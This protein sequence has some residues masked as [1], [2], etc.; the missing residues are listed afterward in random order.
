MGAH[1]SARHPAISPAHISPPSSLQPA[2]ST[3]LLPPPCSQNAPPQATQRAIERLYGQILAKIGQDIRRTSLRP[4]GIAYCRIL[5]I[6]RQWII[7]FVVCCVHTHGSSTCAHGAQ[8][9][10]GAIVWRLPRSAPP[11]IRSSACLPSLALP[12][13]RPLAWNGSATNRLGRCRGVRGAYHGDRASLPRAK[14]LWVTTTVRAGGKPRAAAPRQAGQPAC[15]QVQIRTCA[16]T[17]AKVDN[18][19]TG[20]GSYLAADVRSSN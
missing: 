19:Q 5:S 14:R 13:I 4:Y 18:P 2:L 17:L 7:P 10:P 8:P 12:G 16:Q 3:S 9:S 15:R 1:S 11:T 20:G 6:I